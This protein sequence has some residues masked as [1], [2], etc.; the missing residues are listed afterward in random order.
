MCLMH[1]FYLLLMAR[2][3][4][5]VLFCFILPAGRLALAPS[6]LLSLFY[7]TSKPPSKGRGGNESVC[8]MH[9]RLFIIRQEL[10][11]SLFLSLSP[12]FSGLFCIF[13]SLTD[14]DDDDNNNLLWFPSYRHPF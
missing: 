5:S 2:S 12:V 13:F 3:M 6:S 8:I 10:T 11:G 4:F 7:Q 9:P 14:N 1:F